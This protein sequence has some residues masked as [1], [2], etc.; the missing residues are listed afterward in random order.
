MP[1][2]IGLRDVYFAKLTKDDATGV[3]YATPVRIA[4]AINAKISPK[5][6]SEKFYSDDSVEE[7][8]N[9]FDSIDVEIE[10]NQLTLSSRA[11][12]QGI[13]IGANGELIEKD[14]DLPPEGALL[15]RSKKSNGAFRY[16]A[17]YKGKFQ[18]VED[19][20]GTITDS[21]EGKT[22]TLSGSFYARVNDGVWRYTVDSDE[23][24]APTA[25]MTAWFTTVQQPTP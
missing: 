11:L 6:A 5:T 8:I 7:V 24:G 2:Q 10:V 14:S 4:R 22:P 23:T 16:V 13:T 19:E 25:K 17:L 21:V 1:R 9:T 20:Y 12:L 15:F 18:L 3:T